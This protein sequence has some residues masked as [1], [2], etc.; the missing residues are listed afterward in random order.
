AI[1]SLKIVIDT[2]QSPE[3]KAKALF[4]LSKSYYSGKE[5]SETAQAGLQL[6][7]AIGQ[8]DLLVEAY[9]AMSWA[10][11][12]NNFD[13]Q[14]VA[15][16]DSALQIISPN[17]YFIQA[18][19]YKMKGLV[20]D[21]GKL[22][23]LA[24]E[25]YQQGYELAVKSGDLSVQ[26]NILNN[27]G[28]TLNH[29]GHYAAS[30]EKHQGSLTL[31][32]QLN[33]KLK[34]GRSLFNLGKTFYALENYDTAFDYY[35]KSYK[36]S[37]E[38]QSL[39]RMVETCSQIGTIYFVAKQQ[40]LPT[41]MYLSEIK[42]L[43]FTD[44][45]SMLE[46]VMSLPRMKELLGLQRI[47]L[48]TKIKGYIAEGNYQKAYESLE[49]RVSSVD[50]LELSDQN[51]KALADLKTNYENELLKN[52]LLQAAVDKEQRQRQSYLYLFLLFL[53]LVTIVSGVLIYQQRMKRKELQLRYQQQEIQQLQQERKLVAFNATLNG[54]EQERKRIAQ[55]LHDGLGNLLTT[56]KQQFNQ[57][58]VTNSP[59][60][61]TFKKTN[62]L[63]DEAC[64][65]VRKIAY[66][67]MPQS[68]KR[69]GFSKAIYDLIQQFETTEKT[70]ITLQSFGTE[71]ALSEQ[72]SI[73]LY[74]ITQELLNNIRKHAQA[75]KVFLQLIFSENWLDLIVEDDGKGFDKHQIIKGLGLKGIQ[76]RVEA[77][78]GTMHLESQSTEGT[79]VNI[80]IPISG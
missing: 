20:F 21:G 18:K 33:S 46:S 38:I 25:A 58:T 65:E 43:G 4:Q 63:L 14:A 61:L 24:A 44:P 55:D 30:I 42:K 56:V 37:K 31:N 59:Q 52:D 10:G 64:N 6:A 32:Q 15:Y 29:A 57:L 12:S 78:Q 70:A 5:C 66:E 48:N 11:Y 67:M 34:V 51:L 77:I 75:K 7:K 1:D 41:E 16:I 50:A 13:E 53:S 35:L 74:R 27:W 80:S 22:Y 17:N 36:L 54:Q 9:L 49:R 2:I 23:D 26:S 39:N 62:Q 28:I 8:P 68:L 76:S 47:I 3:G 60:Q 73:H 40:G 19:A 71:Q 45:F 79:C 72:T 69:L